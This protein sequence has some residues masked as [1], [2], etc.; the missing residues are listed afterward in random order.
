[1]S[2]L[3]PECA[4]RTSHRNQKLMRPDR[5]E[6]LHARRLGSVAA[7]FFLSALTAASAAPTDN[8][9]AAFHRYD[10]GWRHFDAGEIL[11]TMAPDVEWTNSA[12]LRFVGKEKLGKFLA[13][14]F[15]EPNFRAGK[16]GPTTTVSLRI[17]GDSAVVSS[18]QVT[19]GQK[20]YKSG[21][22]VPEQ[23]TNEMTVFVNRDGQW[24]IVMDL[25]SDEANGI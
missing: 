4:D 14:L 20:D 16:P 6:R 18:S 17:F 23:H 5:Q 12:G 9:R 15:R 25:T 2:L 21:K 8:V 24:L 11:R 10:E 1:M 22:T 3:S 13:H 19:L 7:V